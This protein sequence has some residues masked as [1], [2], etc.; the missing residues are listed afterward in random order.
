MIKNW[1]QLS[2]LSLDGNNVFFLFGNS[3][4]IKNSF[5]IGL[6]KKLRANLQNIQSIIKPEYKTNSLFQDSSSMLKN[7]YVMNVTDK[8]YDTINEIASIKIHNDTYIL[9]DQDYRKSKK[10]N[11]LC[12]SSNNIISIGCFEKNVIEFI[13]YV[14]A[15]FPNLKQYANSIAMHCL[16][17]HE[18][19]S[20]LIL[21]MSL[22]DKNEIKSI[23]LTDM[24]KLEILHDMEPIGFLRYIYALSKYKTI[25]TL[26]S[27]IANHP[28][29]NDALIRSLSELEIFFKKSNLK[30][31]I[32][33]QNK[34]LKK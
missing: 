8:H 14:L 32:F 11:A 22:I 30:S 19:P 13:N 25:D 21:K 23:L 9:I 31:K 6:Q 1:K 10:I 18:N 7:L 29:T 28:I 34:F 2:D 3:D 27:G 5:V 15:P 26:L 16:V 4:F 12:S 33:I 17:T 20:D 24:E